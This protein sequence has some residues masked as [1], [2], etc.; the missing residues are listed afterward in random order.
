MS[1]S[2]SNRKLIGSLR[3]KMCRFKPEAPY[4]DRKNTGGNVAEGIQDKIKYRTGTLQNFIFNSGIL[5]LLTSTLPY[6][7]YVR[8][9]VR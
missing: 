7:T 2:F 1:A 3:E 4:V 5:I 9:Y 6:F 8:L